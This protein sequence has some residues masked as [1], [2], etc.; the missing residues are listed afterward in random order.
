MTI[1]GALAQKVADFLRH[2]YA[3]DDAM[4]K[5]HVSKGTVNCIANGTW[6]ETKR[7]KLQEDA[8]SASRKKQRKDDNS[9]PLEYIM[10]PDLIL[11][12]WVRPETTDVTQL[13]ELKS[14]LP[15]STFGEILFY[16]GAKIAL[17]DAGGNIRS[18]FRFFII[19]AR[20]AWPRAWPL[21][22]IA[23]GTRHA[24]HV[25]AWPGRLC[26]RKPLGTSA[27]AD[28]DLDAGG[29]VF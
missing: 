28:L 10:V 3:Q 26:Q 9:L 20:R 2:G 21:L 16:S 1:T 4:K 11:G 23:S 17:L 27:E 24:L 8:A 18:L 19:Q 13:D 22:A 29:S 25:W 6:K 14:Y 5:F 15:R 12:V 7:A